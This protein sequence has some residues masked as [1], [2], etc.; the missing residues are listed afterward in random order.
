VL[1]AVP[2]E[3]RAGDVTCSNQAAAVQ[4]VAL[5]NPPIKLCRPSAN[6]THLLLTHMAAVIS[7]SNIPGRCAAEPQTLVQVGIWTRYV[8]AEMS[9]G[10]VEGVKAVFGRCLMQCPSVDLWFMY[11]KF[12]KKVTAHTAQPHCYT[13]D[14]QHTHSADSG[15]H[16]HSAHA[17]CV[18][19]C[20]L[21]LQCHR[22]ASVT[23]SLNSLHFTL[24]INAQPRHVH[25]S[26]IHLLV[27]RSG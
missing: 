27:L 23:N 6:V 8:E 15:L 10:N 24:E 25:P 1:L 9:S 26:S 22:S 21:C 12:I 17:S 5:S 20:H 2:Y 19:C 13:H 11:L 18:L 3:R 7:Y 14:I 16:S 4:L